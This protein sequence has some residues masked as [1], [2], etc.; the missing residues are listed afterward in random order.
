MKIYVEAFTEL[1]AEASTGNMITFDAEAS[2]SIRKVKA[3]IEEIVG[4]TRD[5]SRLTFAGELLHDNKTLSDY[6]IKSYSTLRARK[7]LYLRLQDLVE[8]T[9]QQ[10]VRVRNAS[11]NGNFAILVGL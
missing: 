7:T 3:T 5:E 6:N 9:R 11:P 2:D 8:E 4:I 1:H 10:N